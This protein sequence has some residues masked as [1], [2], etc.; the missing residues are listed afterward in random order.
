MHRINTSVHVCV[1]VC[2]CVCVD[3]T[4]GRADFLSQCTQMLRKSARV[5]LDSQGRIPQE[6]N[7]ANTTAASVERDESER[8]AT[9]GAEAQL[10]QALH[11]VSQAELQ[12]QELTDLTT[13]LEKRRQELEQG[14]DKKDQ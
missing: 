4:L 13:A 5:I 9:D 7:A 12:L 3:A 6:S 11:A 8:V 10:Q 1:C 2:V 14:Q